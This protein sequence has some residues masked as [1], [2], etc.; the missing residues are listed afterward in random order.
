[1]NKAVE[2][3]AQY[4][5]AEG[6]TATHEE[7]RDYFHAEATQSASLAA[8][9]DNQG[10]ASIVAYFWHVAESFGIVIQ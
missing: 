8:S 9:F 4:L 2:D 5:R 7:V 6:I 10:D 3:F 1:M